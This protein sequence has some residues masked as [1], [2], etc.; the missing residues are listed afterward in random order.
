MKKVQAVVRETDREQ[1]LEA[2]QRL[3]V[4]HI[5][6]I[7]PA[8]AIASAEIAVS[9]DNVRRVVQILSAIEATGSVED[10]SAQ[11]A[12]EETLAIQ[13]T[14]AEYDSKLSSLHRQLEQQV[15]WGDIT[16]EDLEVLKSVDVLPGFY[17]VPNESVNK[18]KGEF[19]S[20]L[21]EVDG[22]K[23]LVAVIDRIGNAQI[24]ED[25]ESIQIPT[26]DNPAIRLE[27]AEINAKKKQSTERLAKL[28]SMLAQLQALQVEMEEKSRFSVAANGALTQE[29][30][31]AIQGWV[32]EGKCETLQTDLESVGVTAGFRVTDPEDEDMP[33]SLIKYPGWTTPIKGLFDMLN[34]FPGY[35]E[36]DLSAFFMIAMPIFAAML[37]GD[38]GYGLLFLLLG[39]LF[40]RKLVNKMGREGTH[41]LIIFGAATLIWGILSANFFG[42]G[43]ETMARAGGFFVDGD[44]SATYAA[45][46]AGDGMW[47]TIG[48]VMMEAP[49]WREDSESG[50]ELLIQIS[51]L[52]GTAHLISAHL[53]RALAIF[54][55]QR[56]LAEI[57]W[58]VVLVSMLG[59]I[60][61]MF[62]ESA[63]VS[64][65][66]LIG[67]LAGGLGLVVLFGSPDRNP[68]KRI[69]IGFASSLLP[70]IG[71]FG[72]T[73]SYIRLM[74]VGM[75]SFY[76]AF[77]FND[78]GATVAGSANWQWALA[79]PIIVVGHLLNIVLCLIAIFAHGVRLNMLEF[80]GG[81][82]VQWAGYAYAPF[83]KIKT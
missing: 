49:L 48:Q 58:S 83:A 26:K 82:G 70:L 22:G 80:S 28:A 81:A 72:D 47:A 17:I 24:P 46:S 51:F 69:L 30:L 21:G 16:I 44:E 36:I 76:I 53:R 67:G 27:A 71:T 45:L 56:T 60:W 75:A 32:P 52:L 10:I 66:V 43:P 38:G 61:G 4:L 63:P 55:D 2:L 50:R 65:S 77:A 68:L 19:V 74:A 64:S 41:L 9:L 25:A 73:M 35:Q 6:P 15:M 1:L 59:V 5:T 7:K 3:G 34:T 78:L 40:Y 37:I 20:V 54:P 14:Q 31:F 29:E 57:G 18:V 62:F 79:A 33:P 8:Q 39:V 13:R 42:V 12:A 23:A 11:E